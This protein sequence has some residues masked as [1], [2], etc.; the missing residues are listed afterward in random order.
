M[1]SRGTPPGSSD[2]PRPPDPL[3][4]ERGFWGR[5]VSTIAGVDEVGRGPLA[6]PVVACAVVL[7][8]GVAI[9]GATD[10]KAL[11]SRRRRVLAAAIRQRAAA[12]SLG[13]ASVR[14]I[15]R[16]NILR[17]TTLAMRRALKGLPRRPDH[18]VV[19]GLPVRGLDW[20]HEAL[21]GGDG[22]VHSISCASIVAKVVRDDLMVRLAGRYPGFGW[23]TNAGY[24][25]PAHRAAVDELGSTPHHRQTFLGLQLDLF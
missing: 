1:V 22:L 8:P 21:V 10:S 23:E 24:G 11:D 3:A 20:E 17:A 19:D 25:T 5:G 14:E 4:Y 13:A 2:D 12:V 15:D 9:E 7:E 6:G 16:L 18:V